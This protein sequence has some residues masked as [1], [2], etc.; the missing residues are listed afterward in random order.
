MSVQDVHIKVVCEEKR[1]NS[2]YEKHQVVFVF[3]SITGWGRKKSE[4]QDNDAGKEDWGRRRRGGG[5]RRW[6]EGK[7][8]KTKDS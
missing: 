5:K 7:E 3:F 2:S 6:K 4:K 1:K 8:E